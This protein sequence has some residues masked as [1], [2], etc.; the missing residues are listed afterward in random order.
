MRPTRKPRTQ[1]LGE[2]AAAEEEVAAEAEVAGAA[3]GEMRAAGG[4][5]RV[6]AEVGEEEDGDRCTVPRCGILTR[7]LGSMRSGSIINTWR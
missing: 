5:V 7:S 6:A 4:E 2:V 1:A 3:E